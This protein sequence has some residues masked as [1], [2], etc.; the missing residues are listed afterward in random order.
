MK[1]PRWG[2]RVRVPSS[3]PEKAQV[4]TGVNR[5]S[6]LAEAVQSARGPCGVQ[7]FGSWPPELQVRGSCALP[8]NRA[9]WRRVDY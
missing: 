3:A 6:C 5:P 1:L 8:T 2:S 4:R 7:L 9:G